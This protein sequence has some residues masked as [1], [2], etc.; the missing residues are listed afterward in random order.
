MQGV[1]P[2]EVN[3]EQHQDD[4]RHEKQA[5]RHRNRHGNEELCL[6]TLVQ[7][8][9][10][11]AGHR[12]DGRQ[13][14]RT[15]TAHARLPNGLPHLLPFLQIA[16]EGR[17]KHKGVV[18][19]DANQGNHAQDAEEADLG[20][21][22]PVAE[23]DANQPKR[24]QTEDRDTLQRGAEGQDDDEQHQG[25]N[26]WHDRRDAFL[27]FGLLAVLALVTGPDGGI[28]GQDA[29]HHIRLDVGIGVRG[30]HVGTRQI[31]ADLHL[32]L[33]V[34]SVDGRDAALLADFRKLFQRDKAAVGGSNAVPLEVAHRAAV[35]VIQAHPH[36]HFV[37]AALQTLH[38]APEEA[39]PHL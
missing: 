25:K 28:L 24:N 14:N 34:Q 3:R 22:G 33:A 5:K 9:R 11:Q 20:V 23:A 38:L 6:E 32:P 29:R 37:A 18:H 17:D 35:L 10:R 15:E 31:R 2:R 27:G 1:D 21:E 13:K 39:L 16:V 12:R 30:T 26:E 4:D 36:A 19:E 8:Q 7:H